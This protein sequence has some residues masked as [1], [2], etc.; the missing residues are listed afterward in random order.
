MCSVHLFYYLDLCGLIMRL[1]V[2]FLVRIF[3]A[4]VGSVLLGIFGNSLAKTL[5]YSPDVFIVVFGLLGAIS[6]F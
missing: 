2:E 4:I 1:N 6:G 5:G 3:G